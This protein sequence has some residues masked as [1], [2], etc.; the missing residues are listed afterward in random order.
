MFDAFFV[1]DDHSTFPHVEGDD[2]TWI[3][4][5]VCPEGGV[6]VMDVF[7]DEDGVW[8]GFL[9]DLLAL[10]CGTGPFLVDDDDGLSVEV[11]LDAEELSLHGCGEL[12]LVVGIVVQWLEEDIADEFIRPR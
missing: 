11:V 2:G 12:L 7:D 9:Q 8:C 3:V 1:E 6:L 10:C 4:N 5:G